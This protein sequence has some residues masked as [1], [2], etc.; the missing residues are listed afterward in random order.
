MN[1]VLHYLGNPHIT[2]VLIEALE[3][4][5]EARYNNT[6]V[7][8]HLVR[9]DYDE[10]LDINSIYTLL[11]RY[12]LN[13][14][15][16]YKRGI[17]YYSSK[18]ELLHN[19]YNNVFL[20]FSTLDDLFGY[21]AYNHAFVSPSQ[22]LYYAFA[23]T[24][25]PNG[26]NRRFHNRYIR[27]DITFLL[28]EYHSYDIPNKVDYD[29]K[30][31]FS[32]LKPCTHPDKKTLLLNCVHADRFLSVDTIE[33]MNIPFQNYDDFVIITDIT[34]DDYLE[35]LQYF[36]PIVKIYTPPVSNLFDLFTDYHYVPVA[37]GY[38][39]SPRFLM[40][41]LFYEKTV[42]VQSPWNLDG[43]SY[44]HAK[45][46]NPKYGLRSF[47]LTEFDLVIEALS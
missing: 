26:Y 25:A 7:E 41:C 47:D 32:A 37:A 27:D 23:G 36:C 21:F 4:Y 33:H 15:E 45:A 5:I 30:L 24:P 31:L 16:F 19:R 14:N 9:H 6:E 10:P 3:Y 39:E 28:S 1:A 20:S 29:K 22:C 11:D 44:R 13:D 43:A 12:V 38:D 46:M 35:Q 18:R 34:E 2:G 40:E 42:T 17:K 8:L